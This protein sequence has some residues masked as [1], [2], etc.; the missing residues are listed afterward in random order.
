MVQG[1]DTLHS[2]TS[3]NNNGANNGGSFR[4]RIN[5]VAAHFSRHQM[6]YVSLTGILSAGVTVYFLGKSAQYDAERTQND[7]ERT[8][9]DTE[10]T[11]AYKRALIKYEKTVD[12]MLD[13]S[14]SIDVMK[15]QFSKPYLDNKTSYNSQILSDLSNEPEIK[16]VDDFL[17]DTAHAS[18]PP[19]PPSPPS[20]PSPVDSGNGIADMPNGLSNSSSGK[21]KGKG[22]SINV[23]IN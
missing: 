12:T 22:K 1:P 21:L 18:F 23:D 9:N 10:R 13:K 17:R 7:T 5:R 19:L 4:N 20:S 6:A 8:R 14:Q 11:L 16:A 2:D 3:G 15:Q